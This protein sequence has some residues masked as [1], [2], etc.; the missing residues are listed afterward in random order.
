MLKKKYPEGSI[1]S[2]AAQ[3]YHDKEQN[4]QV[5]ERLKTACNL[6]YQAIRQFKSSGS[7]TKKGF[8]IRLF[9]SV[10]S[11]GR[12]LQVII[13]PEPFAKESDVV[14]RFDK[15]NV[16]I[17]VMTASPHIKESRE[18]GGLSDDF[19]SLMVMLEK[20]LGINQ[21]SKPRRMRN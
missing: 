12:K 1:L 18:L 13:G 16:C 11:W 17:A 2:S 21:E 14:L 6:W 20:E 5:Q 3:S 8:D 19:K 15:G 4:K 9:K 7:W 10:K